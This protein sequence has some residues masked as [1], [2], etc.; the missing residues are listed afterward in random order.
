MQQIITH[1]DPNILLKWYDKHARTLPWRVSPQDRKNGKLPDPY[2]VWLS[3]IMLQQTTI[4]TVIGYFAN[5]LTTW[6]TIQD[7]AG[8]NEDDVLAAWAGLGYYAR[9]R[10]LK[11][12]AEILVKNYAAKFPNTEQELLELPGIGTYTAAAI[13]SI[14]FNIPATVVDGN[15]E[16][17]ISRLF[18]ISTPL[19]NSKKLIMQHAKQLQSFARAG[20]YSQAIMDLGATVCSPTKPKCDICPWQSNCSAYFNHNPE[21]F[22]I[23][24]PKKV[25]PTR[26]GFAYVA[27]RTD[28][29]I[30]LRK[31]PPN[32]LLASMAEVPGSV[33][34]TIPPTAKTQSSLKNLPLRG[35]WKNTTSPVRHTF[36]H[37]HLNISVWYAQIENKTRAPAGHWWS[38]PTAIAT[39]S[40]PTVMRKI[41]ATSLDNIEQTS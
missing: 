32:G 19:P 3:E 33:W 39:E 31:R 10:N 2:K 27:I 34:E 28:G 14:A 35:N 5:F 24:K 6:P 13:L 26:Y 36:T 30:L 16:R 15:V 12:C 23:K 41:I 20:D 29:A 22:P 1:P 8:A 7:L 11:K 40:L 37:F 38:T 17:V 25:K 9:A 4:P 21:E 18:S